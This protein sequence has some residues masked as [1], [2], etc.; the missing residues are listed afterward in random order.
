MESANVKSDTREHLLA[1]AADFVQAR[2]YNAFSFRDLAERVGIRTASIHYHFPTKAD[3][4]RELLL[5]HRQDNEDFFKRVDAE[6][7]NAYVRLKRYFEAFRKAYGNSDGICLGGMMA[8]DSESLPEEVLVEVRHCYA[9]HEQWLTKTLKT[10]QRE[11]SIHL[12]DSP[13]VVARSLFD[14][15]EG[16]LVA[17]R[18]FRNPRRLESVISWLFQQ[19]APRS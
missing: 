16:A 14:A 7:G 3:L 4:G 8:T 12:S 10:G 6:G 13:A 18:A 19:L 5:K 1:A 11:G 15:L 2:G 9:D 17:T